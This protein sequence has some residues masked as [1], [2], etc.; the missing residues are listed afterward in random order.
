MTYLVYPGATHRRFEHS[1]GV[2]DLAGGVF[3]VV[4]DRQN[5]DSRVPEL[6]PEIVDDQARDYWRRTVRM[7]A[8]CHDLGHLPFSHAAEN[9]LPVGHSHE[10]ISVSYILSQPLESLFDSMK[11]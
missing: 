5:I 2:M 10:H 6:V 11:P 4:T 1:L 9:L 3:D 8:L 7:A